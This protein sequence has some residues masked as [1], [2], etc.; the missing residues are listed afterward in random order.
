MLFQKGEKLVRRRPIGIP[1]ELA[2]S[3]GAE[4]NAFAAGLDNEG[5]R[6][7]PA[8]ISSSKTPSFVSNPL[9]PCF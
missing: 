4:R 5:G 3:L 2:V 8:H 9:D 6:L 1:T 7:A